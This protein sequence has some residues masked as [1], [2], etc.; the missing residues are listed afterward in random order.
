M[1]R[2][3]DK[4][5][6]VLSYIEGSLKKVIIVNG[7]NLQHGLIFSL[8]NPPVP[9]GGNIV[10]LDIYIDEIPIPKRVYFYSHFRGCC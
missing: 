7:E 3:L 8:L 6:T 5:H 1:V 9:L 4:T 10:S 2:T